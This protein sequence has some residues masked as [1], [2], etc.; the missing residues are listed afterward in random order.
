MSQLQYCA[1]VTRIAF[2]IK[3]TA[4][5]ASQVSFDNHPS[6]IPTGESE[7][8][9]RTTCRPGSQGP[10]SVADLKTHVQ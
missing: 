2:L 8:Q 6:H 3:V 4:T 10:G 9:L 5:I 7:V 1:I